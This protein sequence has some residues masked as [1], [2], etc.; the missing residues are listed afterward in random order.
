MGITPDG[1]AP[2][3]TP[4]TEA[5]G[6]DV[7]AHASLSEVPREINVAR[8]PIEASEAAEVADGVEAPVGENSPI[9]AIEESQPATE[10]PAP[11]V[12]KVVEVSEVA[13]CEA[14]GKRRIEEDLRAEGLIRRKRLTSGL[15]RGRLG[16]ATKADDGGPFS[17]TKARVAAEA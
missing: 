14:R 9:W 8:E 13:Q 7:K 6:A 1:E 11:E 4:I 3:T 16:E 12:T 10:V 15:W 17:S 2:S 5:A